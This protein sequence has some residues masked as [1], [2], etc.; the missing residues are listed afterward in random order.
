MSARWHR[1]G[2]GGLKNT[3]EIRLNAIIEKDID[4]IIDALY[5]SICGPAGQKRDWHTMRTLFIPGA[6]ILR[7][8]V[9]EGGGTHLVQLGTNEFVASIEGPL[10]AISVLIK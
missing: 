5:D 1:K 7:A 6:R 3:E 9:P 8:D 4:S 2:P 10:H